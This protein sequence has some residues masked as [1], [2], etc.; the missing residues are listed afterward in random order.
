MPSER[1]PVGWVVSFSSYWRAGPRPLKISVIVERPI[2]GRPLSAD[3]IAARL[4]ARACLLLQCEPRELKVRRHPCDGF[5][6]HLH[7]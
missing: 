1:L 4:V 7:H 5:V 3:N 2:H 6:W